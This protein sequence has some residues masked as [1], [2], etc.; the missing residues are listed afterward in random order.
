M[1]FDTEAGEMF[2]RKEKKK[3]GHVDWNLTFTHVYFKRI[4]DFSQVVF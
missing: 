3:Q 2:Y 4:I 1:R